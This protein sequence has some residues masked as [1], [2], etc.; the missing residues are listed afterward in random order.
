MK[1]KHT[2]SVSLIDGHIEEDDGDGI[3]TVLA[4]LLDRYKHSKT[5]QQEQTECDICPMRERCA[6]IYKNMQN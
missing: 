3:M 6:N 5:A 2:S 1:N 4:R